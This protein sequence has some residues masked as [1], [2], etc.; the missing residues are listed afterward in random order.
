MLRKTLIEA[1]KLFS[2]FELE[3]VVVYPSDDNH[4]CISC[5]TADD[6]AYVFVENKEDGYDYKQFGIRTWASIHA[7]ISSFYNK[8]DDTTFKLKVE[9]DESLYPNLIKVSSGRLKMSY[10]LQNYGFISNQAEMKES[11][12]KKRFK[13][14]KSVISN[15]D[16]LNEL[17]VKDILKLSTLTNEKYFRIGNTNGENY[18]YFGDEKLTVDNGRIDIGEIGGVNIWRDDMYFSVDYFCSMYRSL[19]ENLK[20]KFAPTQIIMI[21]DSDEV[22]KVGALRG[23]I[24]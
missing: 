4:C 9:T 11:F 18:I 14:G 21:S 22:I 1:D 13:L 20:I 10:F 2:K 17:I 23:K 16:N 5:K 19:N 8:E 24:L 6:L 3:T 15:G 7:I 12:E